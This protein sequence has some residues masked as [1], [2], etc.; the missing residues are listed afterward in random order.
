MEKGGEA[1]R[2]ESSKKAH[3]CCCC[4]NNYGSFSDPVKAKEALIFA[5]RVKI[6]ILALCWE[7]RPQQRG[8]GVGRLGPQMDKVGE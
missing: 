6:F 8:A 5:C 4:S 7:P 1:P 3:C 2:Q